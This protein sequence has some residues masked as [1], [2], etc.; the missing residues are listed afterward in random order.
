MAIDMR[1]MKCMHGL[2]H[3]P[4]NKMNC[5]YYEQVRGNPKYCVLILI[6]LIINHML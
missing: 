6:I 5:A 4:S 2:Q 3:G 1:T